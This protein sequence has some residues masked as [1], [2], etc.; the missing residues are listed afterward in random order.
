MKRLS[1]LCLIALS[2]CGCKKENEPIE[3]TFFVNAYYTYSEYPDYGNKIAENTYVALHK[4]NGNEIDIERINPLSPTLFDNKG[5]ELPLWCVSSSIT[6]VNFFED[7]PNGKYVILVV[8]TPYPFVHYYSYKK[9]N[10]NYDYRAT[11][12]KILF[13][14]SKDSGYQSW[15]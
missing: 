13:D 11:T 4:D 2:I 3:Q 6:G 10:V 14:R 1:L 12:E 9:I 15:K 8:H 7:I 5:N